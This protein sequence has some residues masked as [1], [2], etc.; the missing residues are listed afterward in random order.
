MP[1]AP[2]PV[3]KAVGIMR[4]AASPARKR[5]FILTSCL[6]LLGAVAELA[7]IGTVLPFLALVTDPGRAAE[8]PLFLDFVALFGGGQ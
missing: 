5:L 3:A 6:M 8:V 2:M 4:A 1:G 7:T